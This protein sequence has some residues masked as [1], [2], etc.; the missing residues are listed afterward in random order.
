MKIFITNILNIY[1]NNNFYFLGSSTDPPLLID[2]YT[3]NV[4]NRYLFG[5]NLYM[6]AADGIS[7]ERVDEGNNDESSVMQNLQ[8]ETIST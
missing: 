7:W 2:E 4:T 1:Q 3:F 6:Y 8:N 5:T